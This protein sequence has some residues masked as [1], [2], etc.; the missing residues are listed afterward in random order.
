M[1]EEV[2]NKLPNQT[3]KKY[4]ED[5]NRIRV[6]FLK[7]ESIYL[8]NTPETKQTLDTMMA[9]DIAAYDEQ[10]KDKRN[11]S[12]FIKR[13]SGG[14]SAVALASTSYGVAIGATIPVLAVGLGVALAGGIVCAIYT[15]KSKYCKKLHLYQSLKDVLANEEKMKLVR[16]SEKVATTQPIGPNDIDLYSLKEIEAIEDR[17]NKLKG[18]EKLLP[19]EQPKKKLLQK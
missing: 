19:S 5:G 13:I 9:K 2:P 17:L 14:I 18:L 16:R 11:Q 4:E 3:I 1:K 8:Q 6:D 10:F 15:S 7:G 12:G